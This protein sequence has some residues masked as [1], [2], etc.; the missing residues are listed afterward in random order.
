METLWIGIAFALGLLVRQ[1]GLPPLVGYLAAGFALNGLGGHFG[2]PLGS[3]ATLERLAHAGV[4]LLLFTVGLKLRLRSLVR[5]EVIGGGLLHFT[6]SCLLLALPLHYFARLAWPTTWLVVAALAFSSTVVAA[7]VLEAKRELRAFHGRV[8]IGILIVQD[9]IA[10]A[11]LSVAGSHSPSPLAFAVLALPLAKPALHRL[12][13]VSGHDELL[14]L[15]GLLLALGLGGYGFA[16]LG[17][18]SELGAL[19]LGALLA[20]HGRASELG[21]ALWGLKEVFLVGFFLQIGMSGLPNLHTF[22]I[23]LLLTLL[24]PLKAALFFVILI[25]LRLRARS[26]FLTALSL[27]SYSEFGLIV[28]AATLPNWLVTLALAV[29]LSFL[30]TAPLNRVAHV[31]FERLAPYLTRFE[32][33]RRHPDEQPVSL[34]M[35]NILI[36]GMGRTGTAAYDYLIRRDERP[37]GLDADQARVQAH[38]RQARRVLYADAEDPSFWGEL[39]LDELEAVML[40][41]NDAE[42]KAYAA[43]QLRRFGFRGVVVASSLFDDEAA[44]IAEAGADRTYLAMNEAG[45][46]L[47]EHVWQALYGDAS[48][49]HPSAGQ[50]TESV[51]QAP[52]STP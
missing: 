37:V 50:S 15:L 23:A 28:A 26:A 44:S 21:K 13:D 32:L 5:A 8:A 1:F 30:I 41:M 20:D 34:G 36:M 52:A 46:G 31:L 27:A 51:H 4:L 48:R 19:L 45:V 10:L 39:R 17:L 42:A 35:A 25:R 22:A 49:P 18:S 33:E 47:A 43:R 24:L 6:I 12:V 16:R 9:L 7:K 11:V 3:S 14:L 29:A 40:C 38:L 2:L